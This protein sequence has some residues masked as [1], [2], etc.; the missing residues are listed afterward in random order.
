MVRWARRVRPAAVFAFEI[1]DLKKQSRGDEGI[2]DSSADMVFLAKTQ[3]NNVRMAYIG[4]A[5]LLT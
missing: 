3:T 2:T 5:R 1:A 4:I